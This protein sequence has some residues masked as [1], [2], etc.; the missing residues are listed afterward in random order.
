MSPINTLSKGRP[1]GKAHS[2]E[3]CVPPCLLLTILQASCSSEITNLYLFFIF[4]KKKSLNVLISWSRNHWAI[5][6]TG[7]LSV[8]PWSRQFLKW[9]F[10]FFPGS[11]SVCQVDNKDQPVQKR[12][13]DSEWEERHT[14]TQ[15]CRCPELCWPA[16]VGTLC[17]SSGAVGSRE[18]CWMSG[19]LCRWRVHLW[20]IPVPPV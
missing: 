5:L 14:W 4:K 9:H 13:A 1:P 10:F 19:L 8:S 2:Q 20:E 7:S 15:P 11:P 16:V 12:W 3:P 6:L 18:Q 17:L